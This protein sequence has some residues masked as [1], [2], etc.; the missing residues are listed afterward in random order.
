MLSFF[1]TLR[2]KQISLFMFNF[3]IAIWLGAILNFGFYKKVHLLTPYLGIKATFFLAATVVIVVA[4]Y[5]AALQILNW[6]W[7]AKIFAILLVFI[8]GFSSY[9]VNTLGVII[10]P[11]QIQNIAQTD[12]AEATDLLSL[13]FGLWT[14][15]FVILPIF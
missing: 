15:F 10:S 1:S 9:F 7:T 13:G 6:K 3:I 11:D 2:N 14:I 5:Y 12:V 4:T 8:G